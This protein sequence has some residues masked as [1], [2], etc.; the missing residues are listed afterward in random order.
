VKRYA[1]DP[2]AKSCTGVNLAANVDMGARDKKINRD[3]KRRDLTGVC[4]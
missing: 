4:L 2:I 3:T 1:I